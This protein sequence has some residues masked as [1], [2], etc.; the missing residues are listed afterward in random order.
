VDVLTGGE[1]RGESGV[2]G[3]MGDGPQLHLV[4][5]GHQQ[6]P[7]RRRDEGLAEPT[8]LLGPDRDVVEVGPV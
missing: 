6:A 4:V 3:K 8:A 5:V 2:P 7:A 1:G